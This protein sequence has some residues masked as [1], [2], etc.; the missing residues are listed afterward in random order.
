MTV[1][2]S[3]LGQVIQVIY[4]GSVEDTDKWYHKEKLTSMR[5]PPIMDIEMRTIS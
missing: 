1:I 5:C 3:I 4:S 2:S